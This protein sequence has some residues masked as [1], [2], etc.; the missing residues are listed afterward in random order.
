MGPIYIVLNFSFFLL[1]Y[2]DD[3]N[4]FFPYRLEFLVLFCNHFEFQPL[5]VALYLLRI[6]YITVQLVYKDLIDNYNY[7]KAVFY[8]ELTSG[9]RKRGGQKLRYK[10]V[11][12]RHLKAA[13]MDVDTWESDAKNRPFWRKKILDAGN[14]IERKRKE[15]YLEGWRKRHPSD[16]T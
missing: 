14:T 3:L 13:D 7:V 6:H 4:K 1:L 2:T 12:K 11:L 5:F 16:P 15:K 8:S 9:K 10:D